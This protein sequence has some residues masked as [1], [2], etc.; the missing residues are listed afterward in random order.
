MK[1]WAVEYYYEGNLFSMHI[2]GNYLEA[3]SH[4]SRFGMIKDISEVLHI[5]PEKSI[6]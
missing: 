5:I 4:A 6:M 1:I 2:Y 3:I